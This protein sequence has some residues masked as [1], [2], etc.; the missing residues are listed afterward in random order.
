MN[1]HVYSVYVGC[2]NPA[3]IIIIIMEI[4][5]FHSIRL[6]FFLFKFVNH[7]CKFAWFLFLAFTMMDYFVT[8]HA[9]W[10]WFMFVSFMLIT[11]YYVV[12]IIF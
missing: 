3:T 9:I 2:N 8:M 6:P 10:W 5:A 12:R 7:H 1:N 11:L 4:K